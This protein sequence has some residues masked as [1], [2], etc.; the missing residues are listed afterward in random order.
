VHYT[1]QNGLGDREE[2]PD[3][4]RMTRYLEAVDLEDED[5]GSAWVT[6]GGDNTLQYNSDGVLVF[7]RGWRKPRHLARV[8]RERALLLWLELIEGRLEA[9]ERLPW[10][11]GLRPRRPE[12]ELER[13]R[14]QR[15]E[16]QLRQDLRFFRTLGAE[17]ATGRCRRGG[18][19]RGPIEGHA[20]C[21]AHQFESVK[22][23]PCPFDE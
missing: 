23:R 18:C 15:E 19:P 4:A 14:Q 12:G 20:L 2:R 7:L 11:P 13:E 9:L 1:I 5:H 16:E 22:G 8:T 3:L 17:S 21:R 6:D 10:Q